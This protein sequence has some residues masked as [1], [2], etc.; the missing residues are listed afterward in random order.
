MA[1]KPQHVY[2]ILRI[3]S[4]GDVSDDS[5]FTAREVGH[6]LNMARG[7]LLKRRMDKKHILSDANYMTYCDK[8][9]PSKFFDCDCIPHE[10]NCNILR[11]VKPIPDYISSQDKLSI[12]V[13]NPISGE[14]IDYASLSSSRLSK[15]SLTSSKTPTWFIHNRH[16]YITKTLLLDSI[17]IRLMPE[18]PS[19]LRTY[20]SC[21]SNAEACYD[22]DNDNYPIDTDLVQ[23]MYKLTLEMLAPS[24]NSPQDTENNA[25]AATINND[26]E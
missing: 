9:I 3:L 23:P 26:K 15:H 1:T 16:L 10:F 14:L 20:Q 17:T 2:A 12:E 11:T 5:S 22:P 13:R 6:H 18:D 7:L 21:D 8:L 19:A 24:F 25:R 4:Q